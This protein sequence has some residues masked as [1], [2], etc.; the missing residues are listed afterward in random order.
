MLKNN[1]TKQ[2]YFYTLQIQYQSSTTYS[3]TEYLLLVYV[4]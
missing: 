4:L 2:K 3:R 1:Q